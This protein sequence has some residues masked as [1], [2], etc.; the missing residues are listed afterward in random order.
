MFALHYSH[1]SLLLGNSIKL[2]Y[3]EHSPYLCSRYC[4]AC[5][6]N[7]IRTS[8]LVRT[9]KASLAGTR[10]TSVICFTMV[11]ISEMFCEQT[12]PCNSDEY[13]GEQQHCSELHG[14][15]MLMKSINPRELCQ[16]RFAMEILDAVM[17]VSHFCP[18]EFQFPKLLCIILVQ[19]DGY[20]Y[21]TCNCRPGSTLISKP[22][23]HTWCSDSLPISSSDF[24]LNKNHSSISFSCKQLLWLLLESCAINCT[25]KYLKDTYH[26]DKD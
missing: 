15:L 12:V 5:L 17:K 3:P 25:K 21:C 8:I 26:L 16:F 20:K 14:V 9:F 23:L 22:R 1:S 4:S 11:H 2:R 13:R 7:S 19:E 24:L 10:V 18:A 6:T